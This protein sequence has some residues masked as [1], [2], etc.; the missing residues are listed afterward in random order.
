M[1]KPRLVIDT[2]VFISA[3]LFGGLPEKV[4]DLVKRREVLLIVSPEIEAEILRKIHQ[5]PI[6]ADMV[7]DLMFVLEE[8]VIKVAPPRRLS[9]CRDPKDNMFLEAALEGEAD[10]LVTGDKDLLALKRFGGTIITKPRL[11]L[12][13]TKKEKPYQS[14]IP[15]S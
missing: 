8:T 2:N 12:E 4:I 11:F 14:L 10:F 1:K 5:F 9:I 7:E 13:V 15:D 3:I 6:T